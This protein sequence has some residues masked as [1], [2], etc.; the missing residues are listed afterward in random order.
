MRFGFGRNFFDWL[1]GLKCSIVIS[2]VIIVGYVRKFSNW[3]MGLKFLISLIGRVHVQLW[4]KFDKDWFCGIEMIVFRD[5]ILAKCP[6]VWIKCG[7][8]WI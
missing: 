4:A 1:L 3:S 7:L 8:M 5:L 2:R 6:F